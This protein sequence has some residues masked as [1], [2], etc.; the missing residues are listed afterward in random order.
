MSTGDGGGKKLDRG[1]KNLKRPWPNL[2]ASKKRLMF[3]LKWQE[4]V[5][6]SSKGVTSL[7][8]FAAGSGALFDYPLLRDL[9]F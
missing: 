2:V 7:P 4:G 8:R 6:Q 9:I 3:W 1:E 5:Y